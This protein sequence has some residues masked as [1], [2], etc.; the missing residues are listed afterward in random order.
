LPQVI[1]RNNHIEVKLKRLQENILKTLLYYDIFSHPLKG[2]EIF[3]FLPENSVSQNVVYDVLK[4]SA[5][6]TENGFAEKEGYYYV[7]PNEE[8]INKR[9]KKEKYS[10]K[11]WKAAWLVTHIIKRFPFV[12]A[13]LVTGSLSK[14]SSDETSDLDFMVITTPNRLWIARTALMLFKKVFLFNSYKYFCINYFI[15]E[16][17]LEIEEKNVFT[18]TEIAHIKGTYNTALVNKFIESNNWISEYFP[19]YI[20]CDPKL[21][22]AGC[23][24]SNRNSFIQRIAEA[25]IPSRFADNLDVR[26]MQ[27]TINHWE[28]KYA[29]LDK[30]ERNFRLRSTRNVSKSHP[31]SVHRKILDSYISRLK[32]FNLE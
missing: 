26:L 9:K 8:N 11:M 32:K 28:K 21:H 20:L 7:K 15:T 18:A 14:N 12:R 4:N 31:D 3:T 29:Y 5:K 10:Q 13:L 22:S 23:K 16:N 19:N 30:A 2:E 25:L 6:K 1:G 17:Y 27:T 24:P